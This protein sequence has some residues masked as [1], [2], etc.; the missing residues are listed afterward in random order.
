MLIPIFLFFFRKGK[1]FPVLVGPKVEDEFDGFVKSICDK[2]KCSKCNLIVHRFENS[3]WKEDS[4]YLFFR[5]YYSN[6]QKLGEKLIPSSISAA[7]CC[8]CGWLS[9]ETMNDVEKEKQ[10]K[11]RC[12]GHN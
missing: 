10:V 1:C 2:L 7:Y 9:V 12:Y 8:Q 5:S 4:E 11:W 3:K 6:Q